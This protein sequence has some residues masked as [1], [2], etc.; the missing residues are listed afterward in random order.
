MEKLT[1]PLQPQP[2]PEGYDT[3]TL[4][5]FKAFKLMIRLYSAHRNGITKGKTNKCERSL[6]LA[7]SLSDPSQTRP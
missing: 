5:A 6:G 2:D 7:E 1:L 3:F 4:P